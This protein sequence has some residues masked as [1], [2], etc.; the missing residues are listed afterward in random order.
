MCTHLSLSTA[1]QPSGDVPTFFEYFSFTSTLK[2]KK[3]IICLK[4]SVNLRSEICNDF[5]L[6][7]ILSFFSLF[8]VWLFL[9]LFV[10]VCLFFLFF[11]CLFFFWGGRGV[12]FFQN[13]CLYFQE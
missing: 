2:F 4:S 8:F 7:G 10:N 5:G 12:K 9:F 1:S 13:S 6:R 11:V 3:G